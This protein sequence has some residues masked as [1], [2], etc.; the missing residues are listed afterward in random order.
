LKKKPIGFIFFI[1][2]FRVRQGTLLSAGTEGA[3]ACVRMGDRGIEEIREITAKDRAELFE[4][5]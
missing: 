5:R 2:E 4:N 1:D 3:G